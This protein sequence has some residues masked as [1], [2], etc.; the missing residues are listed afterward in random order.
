MR[1]PN[2]R[3]SPISRNLRWYFRTFADQSIC[4]VDLKEAVAAAKGEMRTIEMEGTTQTIGNASTSFVA[5]K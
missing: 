5:G 1:S 4:M 3:A 2:G